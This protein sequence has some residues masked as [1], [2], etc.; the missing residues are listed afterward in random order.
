VGRRPQFGRFG[1]RRSRGV[2]NREG[3]GLGK[4]QTGVTEPI[5]VEIKRGT[6]QVVSMGKAL[7]LCIADGP[8]CGLRILC[9]MTF[10]T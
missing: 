1:C 10:T 6:R 3:M 8:S 2:Q 7:M 9:A 5:Q 4:S